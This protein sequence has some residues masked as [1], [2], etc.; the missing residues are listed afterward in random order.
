MREAE[1][2]RE[3]VTA[4]RGAL[5]RVAYL[6]SGDRY[7][8]EDLV[9]TSLTR[10]WTRWDVVSRTG[11]VD[12]YMHRMLVNAFVSAT[13]R[14]WRGELPAGDGLPDQG[15]HDPYHGWEDRDTLRA[16]VRRLPPRQRAVIALRYYLDRTEVDTAAALG[17]SVG[18]VKS[19]NAKA[20]A[21]LRTYLGGAVDAAAA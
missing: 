2:F 1:G 3:Y 15:Q 6:M 8:A 13:R 18:T 5:G 21:R 7:L 4:R 9:Q 14:R 16:A 12:A 11:N 19:Q 10:A 20:I 17:C